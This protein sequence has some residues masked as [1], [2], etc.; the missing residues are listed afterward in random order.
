MRGNP[1][2]KCPLFGAGEEK[3]KEEQILQK[4]KE[5]A[6]Q[7]VISV[8]FMVLSKDAPKKIRKILEKAQTQ[9]HKKEEMCLFVEKLL[10][11]VKVKIL[12]FFCKQSYNNYKVERSGEK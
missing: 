5:Q 9:R 6:L 3:A 1:S 10:Q 11:R 7:M 4:S 2:A 12:A 8:R